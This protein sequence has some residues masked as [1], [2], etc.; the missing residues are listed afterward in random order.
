MLKA[1]TSSIAI[2][3]FCVQSPVFSQNKALDL[4]LVASTS[5]TVQA[6]S[7]KQNIKLINAVNPI[8]WTYIGISG[9]YKTHIKAPLSTTCVFE[10][11]CSS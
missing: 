8:F 3:L 2:V 4:K 6:Q 5:T 9:L 7:S 1:L 10:T 11:R